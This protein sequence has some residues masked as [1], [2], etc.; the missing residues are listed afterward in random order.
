MGTEDWYCNTSWD[1][2]I[3][4]A[5]N[6]KLART[7]SQKAQ[8]LRIQGS[9]LKDSHPGPAIELLQRC[10]AEGD[11]FHVAHAYLDMAHAHYVRG[12]LQAALAALEAALEQEKRQPRVRTTAAYDHAFLVA[13]HGIEERY[14]L[15]IALL[16]REGVGFLPSMIFEAEAAKALIFAAWQRH[17]EAQ[18]AAR[19]ALA[20]GA[21]EVGWIPGH[22]A[23]GL[24]PLVDTPLHRRLQAIAQGNLAP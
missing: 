3:E 13:L 20:A 7:R 23:A 1:A 8:Y 24:V 12:N 6:G 9:V 11:D 10:V 2:D 19:H 21:V 15:S 5:F 4:A 16:D 22:P 14:G 18:Q 17:Q